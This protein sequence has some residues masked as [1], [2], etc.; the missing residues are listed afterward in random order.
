M[1]YPENR[2]SSCPAMEEAKENTGT[3]AKA[4]QQNVSSLGQEDSATSS[5]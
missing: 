1:C 2:L 3:E 4:A 5:L